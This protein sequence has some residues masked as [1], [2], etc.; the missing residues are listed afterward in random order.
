MS[1]ELYITIKGKTQLLSTEIKWLFANNT[2]EKNQTNEQRP[3]NFAQAQNYTP[4]Q[5]TKSVILGGRSL[6]GTNRKEL[7]DNFKGHTL[8]FRNF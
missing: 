7:G 6:F 3:E 4:H 2:E 5:L 8:G 1:I